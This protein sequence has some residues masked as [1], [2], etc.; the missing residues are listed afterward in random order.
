MALSA[1]LIA[2]GKRLRIVSIVFLIC[3]L[4]L[5]LLSP[6]WLG[7]RMS[8]YKGLQTA[9]AFP[10]AEHLRL[11]NSP[12]TRIDAFTSPAVRFAPGISLRYLE[13]LPDQIGFSIDGS[14]INA[15]THDNG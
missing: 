7:I 4:F 12:Y 10:G 2:G 11:Y 14:E 3:N 9:M 5:F 8:P 15:V 6:S 13:R 1:A